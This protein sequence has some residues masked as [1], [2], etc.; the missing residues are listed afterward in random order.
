M[1]YLLNHES[2]TMELVPREL[3]ALCSSRACPCSLGHLLYV[4][5]ILQHFHRSQ[6]NSRPL[7]FFVGEGFDL[8]VASYEWTQWT[9]TFMWFRPPEHNT[10]R[11]WENWVVLL[12]P[13]YL[14]GNLFSTHVKRCLPIHFIAQGRVVT[15]RSGAR[16][17]APRWLKPYT[18]SRALMARSS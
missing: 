10:L 18:A 13:A 2:S 9:Q 7:W 12:E 4:E 1:K 16:Q 14:S 5:V 15:M 3:Q 6:Y 8:L 17:V 11:P